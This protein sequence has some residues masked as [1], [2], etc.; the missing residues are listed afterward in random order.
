MKKLSIVIAVYNVSN[1][2]EKCLDSIIIEKSN[3]IEIIIVDDGSKDKSLEICK[4]YAKKDSR[5]KVIHQKNSGLSGAR[6][7][8]LKNA[9]S[10]YIWFIDGDDYLEDNYYGIIK[11]YLNKNDIICFDY[12]EVK[13]D[14]KKYIHDNKK[15]YSIEEK[16][17]L[18]FCVVWNKII[19]KDILKNI[20]FPEGHK[21]ND[22]YVIPTLIMKTNNIVFVSDSIY[23]YV[24]HD[25]SLSN[26]KRDMLDEH[27]F[28][29]KHIEEVFDGKYYDE[30]ETLYINNLLFY[31]IVDEINNGQKHDYKKINAMIKVKYPSYYKNRFWNNNGLIRK[32]YIRLMYYNMFTIVKIITKNKFK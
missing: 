6:N 17:I 21:C 14:K 15:Y 23:N 20:F 9:S 28:A 3:D 25:N 4:R 16:Y 27:I 12:N 18:S 1:Y 29:L 2:L 22:I 24:F 26:S 11:E 8:G 7:T 13:C 10:E 5:I 19:K 31:Y 32:I 30:L